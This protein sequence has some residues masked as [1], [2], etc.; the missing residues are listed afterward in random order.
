[1]T[2]RTYRSKRWLVLWLQAAVMIA[3]PFI[4]VRGQSVLR[5]DVPTLKLYF[6]GSAIWISEAYFFLLV[7]LLFSIGVMLFTVLYGRIWCGWACPQT[8][9]S[10]LARKIETT[11]SWMSGHP[12]VRGL[13][14]HGLLLLFS[15]LV[16][17]TLIGYF[18]SPYDLL[19]DILSWSI[20]PWTF[21]SWIFFS[22]L[23]YLN[24]AFVRQRFCGS[25]CPYAR[26]QSAFFDD[27]TLTIAFDTSREDECMGCEACVRTCPAG[28]DIR[29]GLQVEC[30][31][32][33][34]CIDSC[35]LQRQRYGK[36]T[37]V[38]Y[39]R[40]TATHDEQQRM[41]SRVWW[42]SLLFAVIGVMLVYQIAIRVPVDFWVLR[43]TKQ[44][45]HQVGVQGSILNA[46]DLIIE[47]RS[48]VPETYQLS[49]SG[50][51]NAELVLR[52]NPFMVPAN[53][54][55]TMRIYVFAPGKDVI[56]RITR[57]SFTLTN[58]SR[59]EIRA[60]QEAPF[61]YPDRSDKGMEI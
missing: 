14:S 47:N 46:Y 35:S 57:I 21:W 25:L 15:C 36:D 38:R 56:D 7:F 4:R 52:G 59:R 23:V 9:L 42:L 29:D 31:N 6:F 58:T 20:G 55:V 32:C 41:R 61:V 50:I 18:V 10:D 1:M 40:G 60:V 22:S 17:V 24:L 19:N 16:A 26:F 2:F 27:Y 8:T 3:L 13:L 28:I 44:P 34:E 30:I 33:A 45:Y 39:A 5:F 48:L 37:L 12:A 49:V 43:D 51:K 11:A 53:S 54:S